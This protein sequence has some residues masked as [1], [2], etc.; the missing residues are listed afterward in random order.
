M[1]SVQHL[2][3]CLLQEVLEGEL[4]FHHGLSGRSRQPLLPVL[5]NVGLVLRTE[6]CILEAV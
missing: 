1:R 5:M 6:A 4:T 3:E 2:P